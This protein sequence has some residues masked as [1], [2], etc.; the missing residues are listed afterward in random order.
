[1]YEKNCCVFVFNLFFCC[2]FTSPM[3]IL[4]HI[5]HLTYKQ[6]EFFS[7]VLLH[8]AG[9]NRSSYVKKISP[10][11]CDHYTCTRF[12]FVFH[13]MKMIYSPFMMYTVDTIQIHFD[14]VCP[15]LFVNCVVYIVMYFLT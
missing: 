2:I 10:I 1:M 9:E 11:S 7:F 13:V 15:F 4:I 12:I 3:V 5:I 6:N 14:I 8:I